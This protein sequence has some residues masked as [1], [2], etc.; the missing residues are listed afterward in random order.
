LTQ[1]DKIEGRLEPLPVG[2]LVKVVFDRAFHAVAIKI[3]KEK[4]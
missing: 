4:V 3:E 1:S 2:T